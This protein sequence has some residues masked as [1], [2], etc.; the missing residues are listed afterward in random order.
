MTASLFC[1]RSWRRRARAPLLAGAT[2]MGSATGGGTRPRAGD[3][4]N[5]VARGAPVELGGADE[6][7][8]LAVRVEVGVAVRLV[9]AGRLER[10]AVLVERRGRDRR[11][12]RELLRQVPLGLGL[13]GGRLAVALPFVAVV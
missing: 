7:G 8:D 5:S 11:E 3:G 10:P 2:G 9:D 12:Q 13:L 6:V 1:S 4:R